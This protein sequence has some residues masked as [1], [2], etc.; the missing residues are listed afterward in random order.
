VL[1]PAVTNPL[2]PGRGN[3]TQ[4]SLAGRRGDYC[5]SHDVHETAQWG[6]RPNTKGGAS[7]TKR[8]S[9]GRGQNGTSDKVWI[10]RAAR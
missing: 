7:D 9:R 6:I 1:E 2:R 3:R 4:H 5:Q 10:E 8:R